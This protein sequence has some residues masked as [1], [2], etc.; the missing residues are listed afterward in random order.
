MKRLLPALLLSACMT[1]PQPSP[2]GEITWE[3]ARALFKACMVEYAYQ[4]HQRNVE[5][6][7]FDGS[8]VTTV[9][10]GLDDI[11]RTDELAP[12]C[13]EIALITE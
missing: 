8:T 3:E 5:L 4:D 2:T 6:T 9:E 11:F 12:G 1:Q 13:P 7:L 10:P